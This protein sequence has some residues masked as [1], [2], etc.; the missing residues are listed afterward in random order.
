MNYDFLIM[1]LST[2]HLDLDDKNLPLVIVLKLLEA[3]IFPVFLFVIF[4]IIQHAYKT[5]LSISKR[6]QL[7]LIANFIFFIGALGGVILT[8]DVMVRAVFYFTMFS[9]GVCGL[10]VSLFSYRL[11]KFR[12]I[13]KWSII[14]WG[15]FTI[16][17]LI[18]TI[19][20]GSSF[21]R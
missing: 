14:L 21:L 2:T 20:K 5:S 15:I 12:A 1:Q 18:L 8:N 17:T 9:A 10:G 19:Q 6:F 7:S 16:L 13:P 4:L 3:S 11:S